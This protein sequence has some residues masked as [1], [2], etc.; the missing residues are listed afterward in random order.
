MDNQKVAELN[1]DGITTVAGY[2]KIY[3][4]RAETGEF[5]GSNDEYLPIGVGIPA[6]STLLAVPSCSKGKVAIYDVEKGC[7]SVQED[8]RG[9]IVYSV[10]TG[11]PTV[12]N[13]IGPIS[14]DYTVNKPNSLADEWDGEKWV[15]NETKAI[16]LAV[17]QAENKKKELLTVANAQCNELMIDFNLGLL[18]DEQKQELKAWRIYIRD[19]K[20]VDIN[21]APDITW[22]EAPKF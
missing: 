6:C 13:N 5:T 10:D 21:M 9:E 7:W 8:H 17:Q 3:N 2:Q 15:L 1:E 4:Y 16:E 19:L 14:N 20:L 22:P 11:E 18:T 12:I